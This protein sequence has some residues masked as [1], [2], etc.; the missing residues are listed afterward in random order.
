MIAA[1]QRAITASQRRHAGPGACTRRLE[2][3]VM[4]FARFTL[5]LTALLALSFD[6]SP[7]RAQAPAPAQRIV[8]L[9]PS[10][11]EDLFAIGAGSQ[12]VGVS[13]Y[14]DFPAAATRLPAVASFT[15]VDAEHIVRLHP[16][17]IVGIPSQAPLAG[18]LRRLGLRVEFIAD[19]SFEDLFASLARLGTLTG[20][21]PQARA[22]AERLRTRTAQL[23]RTVPT[24]PRPRT[25]VT[26]GVAPIFTVGDGSYIAHLIALAGGRN[27]SGIATPYARYSPEALL[28]AQPDAIVADKTSGIDNVLA[29][30]PWNALHAVRD[31]RVY[32]LADAAILER[33]GPRYNDGLA[34]L[35]ARLHDRG[36]R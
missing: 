36:S 1:T 12:V 14:T 28:A 13:Q 27:A 25:F 7:V 21:V 31:G 35:I 4:P 29:R 3:T 17:L 32:V 15:S 16:D 9:M 5:A 26:L 23:V 11:T 20:R 2:D 24:Q 34:W 19:D 22:L 18:D 6:C 10:L 33:P 30:P 8:S